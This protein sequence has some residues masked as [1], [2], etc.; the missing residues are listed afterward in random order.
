MSGAV[1]VPRLI[2]PNRK[3]G[4]HTSKERCDY[5]SEVQEGRVAKGKWLNR[6]KI[7]AK[8]SGGEKLAGKR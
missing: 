8:R 1:T 5:S 2:Q 6:K 4:E 3:V 7:S